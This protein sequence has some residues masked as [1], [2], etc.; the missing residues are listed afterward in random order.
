MPFRRLHESS[1][2]RFC[3]PFHV[4]YFSK[5]KQPQIGSYRNFANDLLSAIKCN[6]KLNLSNDII[7]LFQSENCKIRDNSELVSPDEN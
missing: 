6:D 2:F 3:I 5:G 1:I 4:I 7:V